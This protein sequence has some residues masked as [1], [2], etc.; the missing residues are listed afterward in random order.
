MN[1]QELVAQIHIK[2]SFLCVGLDSDITKIPKHLLHHE[3]PVFE[4]NKAII[5]AT[6][7]YCVSYKINTAFYESNGLQGWQSMQKTIAYIPKNILI[8][9]D[10]KRGDIGN[11]SAQYAKA[12]FE[13]LNCDAITVA[14][15]MGRD[16]VQPFLDFENKWTIVLALTSNEGA[17]D[18]QMI[19]DGG[20]HVYEQVLKTV[21]T[22]GT[23]NNLMYVI[24]AT[25]ALELQHVR[26]IVPDH[27]LLIP[28][29]GAQGGSLQDVFK[30]GANAETGLLVNVSRAIIFA[31]DSENFSS[32]AA[33]IAS[34][35]QQEMQ[36]LLSK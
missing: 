3:D 35:Y 7:K 23:P 12:F 25:K 29:V 22:W 24:G 36:A 33:I 13:N 21:S 27:F 15:Y 11:T 17:K 6:N 16:S 5:D 2:K 19:H 32:K 1:K 30:Y 8:I 14:P 34:G 31:D 9:A 20:Q 4:F 18:F 28:G 10:A 26:K